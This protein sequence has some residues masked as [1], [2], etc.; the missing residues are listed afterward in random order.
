[1]KPSVLA[2]RRNVYDG[3][4]FDVFSRNDIDTQRMHKGK[5]YDQFIETVADTFVTLSCVYAA[6]R[7][8]LDGLCGV[9]CAVHGDLSS[10][11]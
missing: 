11:S 6:T 3:D 1:M 4:S 2:E 5:R 8:M 7:S 9:D 10:N